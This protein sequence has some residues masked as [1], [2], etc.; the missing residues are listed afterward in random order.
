MK[1]IKTT[2][3]IT[4]S[5]STINM[6]LNAI[7]V[8]ANLASRLNLLFRLRAVCRLPKVLLDFRIIQI[9]IIDVVNM[10]KNGKRLPSIKYISLTK[11]Y[12]GKDASHIKYVKL[13]VFSVIL[14][15]VS[16]KSIGILIY[17]NKLTITIDAITIN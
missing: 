16:R 4:G 11:V 10:I 17:N 6:K 5:L 7:D 15:V 3:K 2:N 9:D 12:A 1:L 14:T 13:V 8:T